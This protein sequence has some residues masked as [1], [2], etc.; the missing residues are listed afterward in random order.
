MALFQG[1]CEFPLLRERFWKLTAVMSDQGEQIAAGRSPSPRKSSRR[2]H[3]E[4]ASPPGSPLPELRNCKPIS[5]PLRSA[6]S[7]S[8]DFGILQNRR[9]DSSGESYLPPALGN[10]ELMRAESDAQ[11]GR[12]RFGLRSLDLQAWQCLC[13]IL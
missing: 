13:C 11:P 12:G 1:G 5:R 9:R 10:G 8:V 6:A 2:Q 3:S 7:M 4:Q